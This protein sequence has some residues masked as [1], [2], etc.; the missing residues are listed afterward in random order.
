MHIFN[1]WKGSV[2]SHVSVKH[3]FSVL[4]SPCTKRKYCHRSSVSSMFS[5]YFIFYSIW[6]VKKWIVT[7]SNLDNLNHLFFQIKSCVDSVV[8]S[9]RWLNLPIE[10]H[11]WQVFPQA[12]LIIQCW[13]SGCEETCAVWKKANLCALPTPRGCPVW[14]D[15]IGQWQ[16]CSFSLIPSSKLSFPPACSAANQ[17]L[18]TAESTYLMP[19]LFQP[20]GRTWIFNLSSIA[21]CRLILSLFLTQKCI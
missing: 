4:F 12:F 11:R 7:S 16:Q 20:K 14:L 10:N 13:G 9:D 2:S 1:A 19:I 17:P 8:L 3:I 18:I 15:D 6:P 5:M 21:A